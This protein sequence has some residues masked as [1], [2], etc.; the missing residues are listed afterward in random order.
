MKNFSLFNTI[1]TGAAAGMS[2]G[3]AVSGTSTYYSQMISGA[4]I[5]SFTMYWTGTPT[6]AFTLQG[7][8]KDRPDETNDNDW[9]T[10]TPTKAPTAPAGSAS[11]SNGTVVDTNC[12]FKRIKYV[13]ASG[14]GV[15]SGDISV[16]EQ[17]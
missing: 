15:L 14:S 5:C 10:I 8:D 1:G 16:G 13:N 4:D 7:S 11:S 17:F 6:G 9:F 2:R 3:V 12:K